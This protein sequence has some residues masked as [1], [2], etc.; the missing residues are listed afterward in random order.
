MQDPLAT[1]GPDRRLSV[2][3]MMQCTD[4]DDRYLLRL[5]SRRVLLYTEMVTAAALLHGDAERL[6][7]FDSVEHPVALQVGGSDPRALARAARLGTWAGYDEINLNVGCP[8][9]RVQQGRFG[10]CLMAEPALVAECIA[11]MQAEAAVPVTVK[12]R[13]GIDHHDSYEELC[14]FVET[15]AGAGC[16]VFSVHARKAWLRGLSPRQN[17]EVPPLRYEIVHRLKQDFPGLTIVINGGIRDLDSVQE[18]LRRVD[19]VMIGRAAYH[20]PWMLAGAD[21][22]VFGDD[23]P[24]VS[25]QQV[26]QT[27]VRHVRQQLEQGAR[28]QRMA[29][30]VLGLFQ[31]LP[32]ARAFRRHISRNAPR[33]G[34]GAEVLEDAAR[35][36]REPGAE[37]MRR[38]A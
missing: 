18:Q 38:S 12:T 6:L 37:S 8:S 20:D 14:R 5:L 25:R 34:A 35:L 11:A 22:R 2:A 16:R 32:G 33:R 7:A 28:L 23:G 19:G 36:V 13:I 21:R 27:Y 15:V 30:H 1:T 24:A 3:P 31:G 29:R 9:D 4:R 17:R 26:L 10:A